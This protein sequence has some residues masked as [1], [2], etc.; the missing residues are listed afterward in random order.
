[1]KT[2]K[3]FVLRQNIKLG[4]KL[5][6][7]SFARNVLMMF[8]GTALGQMA[9]VILS[10]ALT[11][12]YTPDEFG[13]LGIYM[14]T[15]SV[16][17]L[18]VSLRYEVAI[19]LSKTEEEASNMIAICFA[20]LILFCTSISII[21]FFVD[22]LPGFAKQAFGLLWPYRMMIPLGLFAIGSYQIGVAYATYKQAFKVLSKTKVYQGYSGPIVQ[23]VLGLSGANIWGMIIGFV[24]GQAS[25]VTMLFKNLM[26][27]PKRMLKTVSLAKMKFL[28]WKFRN[29]PLFSSLSVIISTLAGDGI[30]LITIPA[31]Y[32]STVITGFLFLINRIIGRPLIMISTSILQVYLGDASKIKDSDPEMMHKRFLKLI[33]FQFTIVASWLFILN[34][35][36]KYFVPI[37]FGENWTDAVPYIH[38]FS[39]SYLFG[40]TF[41]PVSY[42]LQILEKQ[43]RSF[44]F[45]VLRLSSVF[46]VL[47]GSYKYNLDVMTAITMY[48][49]VQAIF[50]IIFFI[51]MYTAIQEVRH[52]S[53][54][55]Q[56]L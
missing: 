25:G 51:M 28:M 32:N 41:H 9:S 13:V 36:A 56:T 38:I 53:R 20:S 10:P 50:S 37:V 22:E 42:T 6:H 34:I 40:L 39:I 3:D 43:K 33:R 11:R 45:E 1:M 24:I 35:S 49:C 2:L 5:A 55:K 18:I 19:P 31:L 26:H 17:S 15:V 14:T 21:L 27:E 23:I 16:L 47:F 12:I 54:I 7:G 29:F 46:G 44:I 48:C 52:K 8:I 4:E 30:L